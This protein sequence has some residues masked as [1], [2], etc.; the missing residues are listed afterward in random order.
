MIYKHSQNGKVLTLSMALLAV[1]FFILVAL[2]PSQ[3]WPAGIIVVVAVLIV[4]L[5][6]SL[7]V[8]VDE[9]R[10]Y[11][12]FGPGVMQKNYSLK[13]VASC[14]PV[15][16]PWWYGWGIHLTQDG[17]VYNVSGF[18]AVQIILTNGKKFRVGTDEPEKL[19]QVIL[20]AKK[21]A[22]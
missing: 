5:F 17:W 10:F 2:D 4:W 22:K 14:Q 6:S 13:D 7:N 20:N 12:W 1:I 3:M 19:S 21:T 11:F 9:H 18:K 16:N 15:S 8:A